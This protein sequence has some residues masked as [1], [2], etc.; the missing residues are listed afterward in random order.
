MVD[1]LRHIQT[2]NELRGYLGNDRL[3][4]VYVHTLPDVA[5][6]LYTEREARNISFESFLKLRDAEVEKDV[7]NFLPLADAVIYNSLGYSAYLRT[8]RSMFEQSRSID[9]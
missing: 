8:V 3:A 2:F 9:A 1:G 4:I 7:E 6:A 5:F